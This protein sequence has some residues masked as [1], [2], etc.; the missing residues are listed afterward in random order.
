MP[1]TL[2]PRRVRPHALL[3]LLL[4]ILLLLLLAVAD[5]AEAGEV[6]LA[7]GDV[8]KGKVW[9]KDGVLHVEHPVLGPI[10]LSAAH[11]TKATLDEPEKVVDPITGLPAAS[12][13]S[14]ARRVMCDP[15]KT[16]PT[17]VQRKCK[18]PWDFEFGFGVSLDSGN[19][20][21]QLYNVDLHTAY[22]WNRI[23]RLSFRALTFYEYA[24]GV[25]TEG[26]YDGFL[27]Y[28]RDVSARGYV[29]A[30]WQAH[31][32]DFADILLRTGWFVGYGHKFIKRKNE[33]LQV[34]VGAGAVY[35]NRSDIPEFET[36]TA[37]A[38]ARYERTFR[39]GDYFKA[40][41]WTTP[42][43]DNSGLTP[44]RLEL[45]YGHP[46]RSHLDLTASFFV[47]YVPEPPPGIDPYDTKLI[48]AIRWR[49]IDKE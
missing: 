28:E 8:L 43:F 12:T 2:R 21:K 25:Q 23:N 45:R 16:L 24:N 13:A 6:V 41:A 14:T 34:E 17:S 42:Y 1:S 18:S 33:L 26:K 40:M 3:P 30:L 19:T 49:P 31:R 22:E 32:D 10:Q 38:G 46:I 39:T 11:Y 37:Y 36:A 27:R 7:N 48:F 20:D 5:R 44:S 47:D 9:R 29:F 4:P 35:E 15:P